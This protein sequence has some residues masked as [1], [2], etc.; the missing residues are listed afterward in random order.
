MSINTRDDASP[1][2]S[3]RRFLIQAA[4]VTAAGLALGGGA[5]WAKGR[6]D[7]AASAEAAVADLQAQLAAASNAG[8]VLDVSAAT[9]QQQLAALQSQLAATS[10]QNAQLAAALSAS[11]KE[12]TDVKGL[13]AATQEQLTAALDQL[14]KF[15]T[16]IGLYDQLEGIGLDTLVRDGL[17]ALAAGLATVLGW[18]SLLNDGV[19]LAQ[20][21]I[22]N[23]EKLL[24]DFHAAMTWLGAQIVNFKLGLYAVETAAKRTIAE[25]LNGLTE[26]FGGFVNFVLDHLPFNIGENVRTT[27]TATQ[28]L[29]VAVDTAA[30]DMSG[31]VLD[32]ITKYVNEGPQSWQR[33]LITPLRNKLLAPATQLLGALGEANTTFTAALSD[34]V[35]AALESRVQV[36]AKIEA[37]RT[38]QQI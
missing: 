34:P 8:A 4:G 9:L 22:D 1:T 16:L 14:G 33:T 26:V 6:A 32:K 11:Q 12:A 23:F 13:L 15:K 30:A 27:L 5:A 7:E 20:V 21:L 29:L 28:T 36:R 10:S 17:A 31:Q 2:S 38:A 19:Q 18:T 35:T 37:L 24:P 25:A 3:R